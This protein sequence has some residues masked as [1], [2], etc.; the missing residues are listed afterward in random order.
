MTQYATIMIKR[1][2]AIKRW[3]ALAAPLAALAAA[4]A[5]AQFLEAFEENRWGV[6]VSLT[7]EW[8]APD[9]FR[10]LLDA[11][12]IVDWRGSD[13][14]IGF[15]R[16]RAR[17]GE[18]G[19]ALIRQRVKADSMLCL[20][21]DGAGGGCNDPVEATGDLRLQGFEFH[22]FTP[23]A[24]FADDRVQLGVNTGAGAGWYQGMVRRPAMAAGPVDAGEALRFRRQE[25][26]GG[27]GIPVPIF[28]IE[29]AVA[30]ALAPGLRLMGSAGYGL[31]GSRRIG[32]A[33]SY[34]PGGD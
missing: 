27:F 14:S 22:W 6:H 18:W 19:L 33:L 4:P 16:G 5:E 23:L 7:P 30:G 31:P 28:R 26:T 8:R 1:W 25:S 15:V 20:T 11:H 2:L 9:A 13:Y 12:E 32:V 17:G 24:R 10:H 29:F 34:F 3:V 21:A